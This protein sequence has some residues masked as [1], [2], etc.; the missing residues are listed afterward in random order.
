MEYTIVKQVIGEVDIKH[1]DAIDEANKCINAIC[2]EMCDE[3]VKYKTHRVHQDRWGGRLLFEIHADN[4][5][6]Y[7]VF[8]IIY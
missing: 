4:G 1:F 3:G 2:T 8:K 7:S 5:C 6:I